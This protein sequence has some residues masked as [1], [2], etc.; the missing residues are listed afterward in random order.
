MLGAY[1]LVSDTLRRRRT[2]LV[3]HRL[4]GADHAAIARVVTREFIVPLSIALALGLPIG[5]WLG[6][7]YLAGFIDRVNIGSGVAVPALL[8]CL[9]LLLVLAIAAMRHLRQA[10]NL[11]PIEALR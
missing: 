5:V 8:A 10:L 6:A 9:A 1:A 7:H 2:E 11:Q 4:H 3:L